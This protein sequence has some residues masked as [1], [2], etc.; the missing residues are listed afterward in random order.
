[1]VFGGLEMSLSE[2]MVFKIDR[3]YVLVS[4]TL[5]EVRATIITHHAT[6]SIYEASLNEEGGISILIYPTL[7][8]EYG[9]D[10]DDAH[11]MVKLKK[12]AFIVRARSIIYSQASFYFI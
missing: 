4:V 2:V 11:A 6:S 8:A 7:K 10:H 3:G 5:N 12:E 9:D 1:M